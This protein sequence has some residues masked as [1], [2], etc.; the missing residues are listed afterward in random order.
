VIWLAIVTI[1]T[2]LTDSGCDRLTNAPAASL[3]P[4]RGPQSVPLTALARVWVKQWGDAAVREVT[5][6]STTLSKASGAFGPVIANQGGRRSF[7]LFA[8]GAF[9][10][11]LSRMQCRYIAVEVDASTLQPLIY[12]WAEKSWDTAPLGV[13]Y[14]LPLK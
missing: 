2:L 6:V 12:T 5:I 7:A 8:S 1:G 10:S 4:F 3:T 11:P 14:G 13:S 9:T